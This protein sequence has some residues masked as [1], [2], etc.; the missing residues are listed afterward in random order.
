MKNFLK[1]LFSSRHEEEGKASVNEAA[2]QIQ[3]TTTV[4]EN[5]A[6]ESDNA[7]RQADTLKFD[8]IRAMNLG[9]MVFATEALRKALELR[10]E[11]ETR[12]YLAEVLVRRNLS[13]EALAE[14]DLLLEEMPMHTATRLNRSKLRC[15]LNNP[16]GAL[17]DCREGIASTSEP[18]EQALLLYYGAVALKDLDRHPEAID[19][20]TEAIEKGESFVM[21]RLLRARLLME[22][23][24]YDE[25]G[26]DLDTIAASHPE[27]EQVPLLRARLHL[28]T[29]KPEEA[30]QAYTQ[31]LELD[32]FSEEGH[33]GMATLMVRNGNTAEAEAFLR[34]AI[35]E[36][37]TQ[38]S[39]SLLLIDILEHDG[40]MDEAA[41]LRAQLPEETTGNDTVNFKN[42][43]SGSLF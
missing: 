32:P 27:E 4:A 5:L 42:L 14:M 36:L 40:R 6:T 41:E 20:L 28:L 1:S 35:E 9:E 38:R 21:A 11:F 18:E 17:E 29:E 2:E 7:A 15:E 16:D 37:P 19:Y 3:T 43:Y 10:P 22:G 13:E 12:Y 26:A 24:R 31:L 39:L 30:M 34:E 8:A 33:Q 25:A 23:A